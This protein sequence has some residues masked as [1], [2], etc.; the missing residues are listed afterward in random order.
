MCGAGYDV[1]VRY[2][3]WMCSSRDET[4]DVRHVGEVQCADA[5]CYVAEPLEVDRSGV[6]GVARHDDFWFEFM[7]D[8]LDGVVVDH[9]RFFVEAVVDEVVDAT[10]E[11][12][13]GAVR[14]MSAVIE[15][16]A[17]HSIAGFQC[18]EVCGH[19][20]LRSAVR[21]DV[22]VLCTFEKLLGA[23]DGEGFRGVDVFG[24]GVVASAGIAFGVFVGQDRSGGL[25]NCFAGV[26]FGGDEDDFFAQT[27][28][29]GGD[30]L[31]DSWVFRLQVQLLARRVSHIH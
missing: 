30:D 14:E 28:F 7:G 13:R 31:G 11:V 10:G 17:H 29:F 5:L 24:A 4:G 22:C 2:R 6:G 15:R 12:D 23:F 18:G 27:A 19:V 1:G 26:V 9:L 3:R 20:G 16:H 21:L 8:A 25:E